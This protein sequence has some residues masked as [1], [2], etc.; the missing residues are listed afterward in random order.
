MNEIWGNLPQ[1]LRQKLVDRNY[2]DFTPEYKEQ[3]EE[4]FR[5]TGTAPKN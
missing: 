4:Y 5:K 3:I 2:D 1:E